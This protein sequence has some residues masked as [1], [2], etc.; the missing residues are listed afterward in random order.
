M[1]KKLHQLI[2]AFL[3]K[4]E[5]LFIPALGTILNIKKYAEKLSEKTISFTIYDGDELIGLLTCHFNDQE[6]RIGYITI[7]V[8]ETNDRRK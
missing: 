8:K 1:K 5:Y 2:S 6:S 4:S 3:K 7:L